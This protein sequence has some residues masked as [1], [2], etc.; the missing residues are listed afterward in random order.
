[1]KP[2]NRFYT[3]QTTASLVILGAALI[4][5][6]AQS[7]LFLFA[8]NHIKA[9]LAQQENASVMLFKLGEVLEDLQ[10][11]ETGQRGYLLTGTESYLQ[12]YY[13]SVMAINLHMAQTRNLGARNIQNS[14]LLDLLAPVVNHKLKE[15]DETIHLWRSGDHSAAL[16]RVNENDGKLDMDKARTILEKLLAENRLSR[17]NMNGEI[18]KQITWA[19]YIL[20]SIALTI[21][22][23]VGIATRQ[24]IYMIKKNEDITKRLEAESTHDQLTGLP[25]RRLLLSWIDKALYRA[26]RRN[27]KIAV[28]FIDLDGFKKIND[29][30]GH[31]FGDAVLCAVAKQFQQVLRKEDLLARFGGDEFAV[32]TE[33]A[34]IDS[35]SAVAMRLIEALH[36]PTLPG[37][38]QGSI[39]ASIGIA[40]FPDHGDGPEGLIR[41]ADSAMY[42]AKNA[43]KGCFRFG[44][45]AIT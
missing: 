38:P 8:G 9:N 20:A 18:E 2:F 28:L 12:P 35:L 5:L 45:N 1:M 16:L 41:A 37:L 24:M 33:D 21:I 42:A 13:R 39:G 43:G 44:K 27:V 6:V 22:F 14:T 31:E 17:T 4:L 3:R 32:V 10:D 25:N 15:L 7:T 11:A 26:K 19:E 34:A 30:F 40:V 36:L 23:M 29:T